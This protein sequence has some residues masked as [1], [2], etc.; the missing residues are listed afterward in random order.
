MTTKTKTL[1]TPASVT[2]AEQAVITECAKTRCVPVLSML[3]AAAITA[4]EVFLSGKGEVK[5]VSD[6]KI[7]K[8]KDAQSRARAARLIAAIGRLK[9][10]K[11]LSL[12]CATLI[13]TRKEMRAARKA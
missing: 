10:K 2:A 11:A 5:T 9:S 6:F 4:R 7:E 13:T 1:V 12:L 3:V 8:I